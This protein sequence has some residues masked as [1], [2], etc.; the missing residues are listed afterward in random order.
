M[1]SRYGI[2]KIILLTCCLEV[3]KIKSKGRETRKEFVAGG[4]E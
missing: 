1:E 3:C 4:G 2:F